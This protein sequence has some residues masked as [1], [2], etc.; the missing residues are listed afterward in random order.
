MQNKD[1]LVWMDMEMTGLSPEHD[2]I[3]E[4]ATIITN[5]SLDIIAQGPHL[6]I[7]QP[8]DKLKSMN[9]VVYTMHTTSGLIDRVRASK[10]TLLDAQQQ[11]LEFIKRY[12]PLQQSPLCGNSIYQDRAFLRCFMPDVNN[13]LHYRIIDVS[14][15]KELL[16]RW[17]PNDQLSFFEKKK[18][19]RALDDIYE[20]I[21]ELRHY[22]KYFFKDLPVHQS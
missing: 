3:L 12:C 4:I 9:S 10:V 17:Y 15:I 5:G 16:K 21:E 2:V 13:F 11:T 22:K 1:A 6:V 7:A 18:T 14:S 19:H 20:S 8:E